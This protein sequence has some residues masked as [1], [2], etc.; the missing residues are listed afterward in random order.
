M[1]EPRK[2]EYIDFADGVEG[3]IFASGL[4]KDRQKK[5]MFLGVEPR[6]LEEMLKLKLIKRD[7]LYDE[8]GSTS[9][10]GNYI[11]AEIPTHKIRNA[12]HLSTNPRLWGFCN[13]RGEDMTLLLESGLSEGEY[14]R[15]L[16]KEVHDLRL[17]V[18]DKERKLQMATSDIARFIKENRETFKPIIEQIK[19]ER[20]APFT[21]R[22]TI[23]KR[24]PV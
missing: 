15:G 18:F 20:P 1:V 10:E 16:E 22:T 23:T 21:P 2:F 12:S 7:E 8:N 9:L 5:R 13:F 4:S 17:Q 24:R 6:I 11:W 3:I 14:I 19:E